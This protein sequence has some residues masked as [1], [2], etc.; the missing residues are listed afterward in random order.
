VPPNVLVAYY[1]RTGNTHRLATTVA[2]R[3][4]SPTVTRIRPTVDRA[5]PR[6]LLRSFV[7]GSAVRIEPVQTDLRSYDAVFLGTP[8]WTFSCPPFTAFLER[9]SVDG[10]PTGVFLTYGGFDAERY[11]R[12]LVATLRDRGADVRATLRVQRDV[13]GTRDSAKGVE[14]FCREVLSPDVPH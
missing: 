7:P 14:D 8:K 6:W 12:E 9:L 4:E 3:F 11:L 2:A 10:V 5:Y 13:V 1:S